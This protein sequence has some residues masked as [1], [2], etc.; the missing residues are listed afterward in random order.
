MRGEG[1]KVLGRAGLCR[2]AEGR[3]LC[4]VSRE[5]GEGL[6]SGEGELG[7]HFGSRLYELVVVSEKIPYPRAQ[8]F[9]PLSRPLYPSL[10]PN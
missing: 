6:R 5:A 3:R 1:S 9:S 2:G 8:S 4:E 7:K 10:L